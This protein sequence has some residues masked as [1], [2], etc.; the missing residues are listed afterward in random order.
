MVT[1]DYTYLT[2]PPFAV[3]APLAREINPIS[4]GTFGIPA[5]LLG[6]IIGGLISPAAARE[7]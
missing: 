6:V 1:G 3:N 5:V 4:P 2:D 7:I